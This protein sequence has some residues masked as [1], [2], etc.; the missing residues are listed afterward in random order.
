MRQHKEQSTAKPKQ[1]TS[2]S[3]EKPSSHASIEENM[4]TTK[5]VPLQRKDEYICMGGVNATVLLRATRT[6][7]METAELLGA[8]VLVDEHWEVII[9]CPKNTRTGSYKVVVTYSASA[10]RSSAR[11][12][13]KPI[14]MDLA[15]GVEG[16]MTILRR[17]DD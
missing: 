7:L 11:D 6:Q 9:N 10:T 17:N 5:R 16:L 12:P 1:V 4:T 3:G 13:R 15:K 2:S 8:N 14:A